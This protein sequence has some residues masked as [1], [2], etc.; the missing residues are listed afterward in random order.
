[1]FYVVLVALLY[2]SNRISL[3]A[4][5]SLLRTLQSVTLRTSVS[6][7]DHSYFSFLKIQEDL[8]DDIPTH[9]WRERERE[10][11]KNR[12]IVVQA[13]IVDITE[14]LRASQGRNAT[15]AAKRGKGQGVGNE[16]CGM[17]ASHREKGER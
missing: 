9:A 7:S 4:I 13:G 3:I 1:M 15:S 17:S 10:K 16:M 11:K 6:N 8:V 2:Q 5:K 12:T 14:T